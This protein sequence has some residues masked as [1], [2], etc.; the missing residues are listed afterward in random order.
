MTADSAPMTGATAS[1]V[2][3]QVPGGGRSVPVARA[4]FLLACVIGIAYVASQYWRL[5]VAFPLAILVSALISVLVFALG[6]TLLRW[7]RPVHAPPAGA[8][9]AAFAWGA[10]GACGGALAANHLLAVWMKSTSL[11]F[12]SAWAAALTA[13]LNEEVM[14]A[15]GVALLALAVPRLIRGPVDGMVFGALVGLGFEILENLIYAVN[16]I[17]QTGATAPV[18]AVLQT[19]A[20]RQGV[21]GLGSHWTMAA[22]SG[23]G[24]GFLIARGRRGIGPFLGFFLLAMAMH[25]L[26]DS[27]LLPGIAGVVAKTLL[28]FVIAAGLFLLLRRRY[29]KDVTRVVA[30]WAEDGTASADE[31]AAL[32]KRRRRRKAVRALPDGERP[33]AKARQSVLL[34]HLDAEAADRFASAG[35]H[36]KG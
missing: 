22:V 6:F 10:T 2:R 24:I 19:Y 29:R 4:V 17:V 32:P 27:P 34:Y 12:G 35:R 31:A 36:V 21:T 7:F 33:A 5:V 3:R 18:G 16:Q 9:F 28:N 26:F 20:L 13:P 30:D 25:W 11:S 23:A 1:E 15:A 8:S 14:K